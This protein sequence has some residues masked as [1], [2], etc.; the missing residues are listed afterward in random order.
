MCPADPSQH[1]A[2]PFLVLTDGLAFNGTAWTPEMEACAPGGCLGDAPALGIDQYGLWCV[3]PPR[4]QG[5]GS[6]PSAM[7]TPT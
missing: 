7:R 3:R 1:W 5:I 2:G 4:V 6:W